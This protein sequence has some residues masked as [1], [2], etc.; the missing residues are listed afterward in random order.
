MPQNVSFTAQLKN[1]SAMVSSNWLTLLR[2]QRLI[3]VIRTSEF[4][5][6]RK[7]AQ[8]MAASG[9]PLIEITWNSAD[10]PKLIRQLR[11]EL[12]HCTIGTGTIL[13][14]EQLQEAIDAGVQFIF[15]PHV[16]PALIASAVAAQVPIV[17]GA[18][19]PTEIV[20]A[21]Q[22][23]ASAVKVFPIQAVGGANYIK[24]LQG[25]LGEI[26]L[27]PTGGVTLENAQEFLAAGAIAVG[28]SGELFPKSLINAEDWKA[29]A[30]RA[31]TLKE[32]LTTKPKS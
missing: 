23:G 9:I 21:W 12:P 7:M 32:Q 11:Q 3:A 15:T 6:G 20:T 27:I 18:L 31:K 24:A 19:T 16:E 14:Q 4:E 30:I 1:Q 8:V 28:L 13:N 5:L 22:A 29:I 10:A 2:Q 17:P 26:P 25:P